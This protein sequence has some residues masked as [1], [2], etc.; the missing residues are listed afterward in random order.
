MSQGERGALRMSPDGL[1]LRCRK[2][3]KY[4]L[5]ESFKL[6]L[7]RWFGRECLRCRRKRKAADERRR[8]AAM[9][10]VIAAAN[11]ATSTARRPTP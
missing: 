1:E 11:T 7:G 3:S 4:A 8:Y 2:C 5:L 9:R 6:V 10:S